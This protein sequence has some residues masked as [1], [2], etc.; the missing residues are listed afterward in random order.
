MAKETAKEAKAAENAE[1]KEVAQ[2]APRKE[3]KALQ[4]SVYPVSELAANAKKIFGTRPECVTA[5][6]KAAGKSEC[7]IP[8]AKEI[9]D[10]FLKREVR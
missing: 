3:Q 9:V 1:I 4:E 8:K 6:L 2:H 5:A 10:K 7:T